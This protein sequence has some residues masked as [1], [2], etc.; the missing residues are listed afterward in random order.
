MIILNDFS[1][2]VRKAFTE[3]DSDWE[4]YQ[5]L[6]V[7]GTH[8]PHFL[9]IPGQIDMLKGFRES[10]RPALG[11]CFGLQLMAIECAKNVYGD[12]IATSEELDD[13]GSFIVVKL[14]KLH[15]GLFDG[16]SYWNNYEVIPEFIEMMKR[17]IFTDKYFGVQFHPEYQS[18]KLSPHPVLKQF[19]EVC[20]TGNV[21]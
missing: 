9:D 1:T 8:S 11:I 21:E 2:S 3:I 14:P 5:G 7:C 16:E 4:D 19:L 10:G 6:V 12:K 15:I 18:S 20:K 17:D 13:R